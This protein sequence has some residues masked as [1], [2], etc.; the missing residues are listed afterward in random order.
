MFTLRDTWILR[1]DKRV[2]MEW[3]EIWGKRICRSIKL[4]NYFLAQ[5]SQENWPF[6]ATLIDPGFI[7]VSWLGYFRGRKL[8]PPDNSTS[9]WQPQLGLGYWVIYLGP[10]FFYRACR[11]HNTNC[12]GHSLVHTFWSNIDRSWIYTSQGKLSDKSSEK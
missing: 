11:E 9:S 1:E 4:Y 8:F 7:L 3:E 12:N 2:D 6:K 5:Y 10:I